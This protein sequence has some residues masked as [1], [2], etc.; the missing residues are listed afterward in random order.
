MTAPKVRSGDVL[1]LSRAASPQF[2][3]PITVRVIRV[4][5]RATYDGWLWIDAYQLGRD[6]LALARRSLYFMPE[7]AQLVVTPAVVP[8]RRRPVGRTPVR[9]GG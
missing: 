3:R 1:L 5:D 9:V 7:G 8:G 2:F 4:L 6:G